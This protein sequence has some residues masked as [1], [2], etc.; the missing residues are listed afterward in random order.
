MSMNEKEVLLSTFNPKVSSNIITVK[1]RI[2]F[3]CV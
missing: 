2:M 1:I 3:R